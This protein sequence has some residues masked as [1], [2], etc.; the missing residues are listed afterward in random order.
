MHVP[1]GEARPQA[2]A[3]VTDKRGLAIGVLT[4]DCGPV[5][6]AAKKQ[7]GDPVIGAAHAGW[8]GALK[9]VLEDTVSKMLRIGATPESIKACGGPC[10][11]TASYEFSNDLSKPFINQHKQT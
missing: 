4:A 10:I 5:L 2:D 6:F 1:E 7:N 9:D 8:G 3:L 11:L